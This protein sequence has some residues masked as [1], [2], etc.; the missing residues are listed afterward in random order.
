VAITFLSQKSSPR[1]YWVLVYK[2]SSPDSISPSSVIMPMPLKSSNQLR[3]LLRVIFPVYFVVNSL[4]CVKE[5][6]RGQRK[7]VR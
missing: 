3:F 7:P 1:A 4:V 5:K 6:R 2:D